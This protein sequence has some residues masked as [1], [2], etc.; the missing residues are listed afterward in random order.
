MK[1]S[2][3]TCSFYKYRVRRLLNMDPGLGVE[4]FCE[5]GND[6]MW[7]E[8][9]TELRSRGEVPFSIHAPFAFVD[10]AAE[11]NETKLFEML[12]RPF[13]L[14]HKF[15]GEFYVVHTYGDKAAA[16]LGGSA[17]DCRSRAAE[18]FCKLQDICM[19]EGVTLGA[20]NLCSGAVPLFDEQ[21]YL[22]LFDAVPNMSAVIDV[23]HAIVSGMDVSNLQRQLN[24]RICAYHLH[25]NDGKRDSHVR[26]GQGVFDWQHFA[27]DCAEFTPKAVG[28]LE[29][30][31]VIDPAAY[32]EDRGY[33][34]RLIAEA[35]R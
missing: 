33:M 31:D 17:A 32:E 26:L 13:D 34:E 15:D 7:T 25:D 4:I 8:L 29:Y 24:K 27:A 23:G 2:I 3:S 30:M 20:E 14:Y 1:Y 21:Q 35:G 18:R 9:M 22:Q 6:D 10:I 5:F 16:G 12:K 28:V 11:E 19:A